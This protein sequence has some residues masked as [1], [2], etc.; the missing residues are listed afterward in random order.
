MLKM[1]SGIPYKPEI[2]FAS[3]L[4]LLFLLAFNF[5]SLHSSV[6]MSVSCRE[7]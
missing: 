6:Y 1:T 3:L 2:I 4:Y 7:T 5:Y